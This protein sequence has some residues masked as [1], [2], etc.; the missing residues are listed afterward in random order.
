MVTEKQPILLF[1][2]TEKEHNIFSI[3]KKN[4]IFSIWKKNTILLFLVTGH[5]CPLG[6][7]YGTEFRCPR[8][9]FANYTGLQSE[10]ECQPCPGGFYCDVEAQTS[11]SKVCPAG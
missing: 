7:R 6:T 2:V 1:M 11:Y 9:T 8:G 5:Y 4:D 3:L 10:G